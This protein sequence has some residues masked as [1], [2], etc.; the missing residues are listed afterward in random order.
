ME[1]KKLNCYHI[2]FSCEEEWADQAY[3]WA[4]DQNGA[5]RQLRL[6]WP[7]ASIKSIE[8]EAEGYAT[9]E[10][11][12]RVVER[13]EQLVRL[14]N[15]ANPAESYVGAAMRG[16]LDMARNNIER[17]YMDSMQEKY[18]VA[19][20]L[21]DQEETRRKALE[22]ELE[23]VR[24]KRAAAVRERM[25][26]EIAAPSGPVLL[27]GCTIGTLVLHRREEAR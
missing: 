19:R 22:E 2:F 23:K 9:K 25:G 6:L 7:Q 3:F 12:R 20:R 10:Q 8:P 27:S 24:A 11:E 17:D 16:V 1:E 5:V 4:E 18:E 21:A 14:L 26:R 15:P 13:I